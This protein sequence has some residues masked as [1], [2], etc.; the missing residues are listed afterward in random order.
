VEDNDFIP[1]EDVVGPHIHYNV[2]PQ[3]LD[4]IRIVVLSEPSGRFTLNEKTE[5]QIE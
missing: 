5:A 3:D 1:I 2:D 4:T